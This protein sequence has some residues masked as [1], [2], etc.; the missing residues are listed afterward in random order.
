MGH[1]EYLMERIPLVLSQQYYNEDD[2][3]MWTMSF[4]G[5][6]LPGAKID[7]WCRVFQT[8][9][10]AQYVTCERGRVLNELTGTY[11]SVT[12]F[13][14]RTPGREETWKKLK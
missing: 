5:G 4:I 14:G 11:P 8:M 9:A 10:G 3:G 6:E 2:Q 7:S 1:R 12:H 13:N